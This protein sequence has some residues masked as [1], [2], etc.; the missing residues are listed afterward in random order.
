M[1]IICYHWGWG[2]VCAICERFSSCVFVFVSCW[3]VVEF[4]IGGYIGVF[5]SEAVLSSVYCLFSMFCF[6]LRWVTFLWLL[7]SFECSFGDFWV[8][9]DWFYGGFFVVV[10]VRFHFLYWFVLAQ[11]RK[12]C[13]LNCFLWRVS[14]VF[15]VLDFH[16]VGLYSCR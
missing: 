11:G 8:F 7:S 16:L 9:L 4:G 10:A 1:S 3:L 6:C 5:F 14:Y 13:H 15:L 2:K 12:C